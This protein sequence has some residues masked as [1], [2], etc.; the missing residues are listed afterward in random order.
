MKVYDEPDFSLLADFLYKIFYAGDFGAGIFFF[1][2]IPLSIQILPC[3][4]G[5]V[6]PKNNSVR[7]YHGDYVDYVVFQ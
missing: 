2:C 4:V 1:G 7:V 3:Q 5:S 6:V